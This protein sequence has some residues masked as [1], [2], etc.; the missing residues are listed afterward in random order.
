MTR[1][2]HLRFC[3]KCNNRK[4]DP[5]QGLVCSLTE[6]IADFNV[7]CKD[8]AKD[9]SVKEEIVTEERS[10]V[11]IIA[12]L[13]EEIKERLRM[14]QH[15]LF[16][17][18]GGL[19]VSVICALLWAVITVS[20]EYQIG[21]MALG[22]GLAVGLGVRFFGSGI[23]A[24]YGFIGA[25]LALLGCALGNLF[26]AVGFIAQAESLGY[27]DTIAFL[28]LSTMLAIFL[29]TFSLMDVLFY[30]IAAYEGYRF[31]FR[32]IPEDVLQRKDL[33]PDYVRFK[34]PLV[35]ASFMIITVSGYRLSK[36]VN[37][38][39]TF[40]YPSGAIMSS[41]EYLEGKMNGKWQHFDENGKQ[42]VLASYESGKENGEWEWY[43]E[44]G[45]LKKKGNYKNGLFD[46]QW[47]NYYENGQLNDSSNYVNGRLDGSAVSYYEN[48]Q[49]MSIGQYKRDRQDGL[50]VIFHGNGN[51]SSEG[52]FVAGEFR[53]L[54]KYW[55]E[56]GSPLQEFEFDTVGVYKIINAWDPKGSQ[57]VKNGNGEYRSYSEN[58]TLVWRG[59]VENGL[60]VG[61][62]ETFHT[63]GKRKEEGRYEGKIYKIQNSWDQ[64]GLLQV[65]KGEGEYITYYEN[66]S[67]VHEKGQIKNGLREGYW[68][69][70]Y[71]SS[72][73]Q[74]ES[75][76]IQG[77]LNGDSNSYYPNGTISVTGKFKNDGKEGE[78]KW[79]Y[80]SGQLHSSVNYIN[81]K[82]EGAQIFWSEFGNKS[83]EEIYESNKLVSE[84]LL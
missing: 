82:K 3:K 26:S 46:G 68:V 38:P 34:L 32:P 52:N 12:E 10:A 64:E 67:Q 79:F 2:E 45:S 49:K 25:L 24:I 80:E 54:W 31:A 37:G 57:M 9:T 6:K 84:K 13:P 42:R 33:T 71:D 1:E 41:G 61:S 36:G 53:G 55:N 35:I 78:W 18:I 48:G 81:N 60:K 28:D 30:G 76:Y 44:D 73:L 83:K 23:D 15:L 47:L 70:Y 69:T 4:L 43:N 72:L 27:W 16:A 63:N 5:Q 66:S 62:W 40:Y 59:R 19:F 14:H 51:K 56:D 21:Y 8:F 17:I 22:L 11:E 77:K 74:Q 29:E 58:G 75:N 20:T 50:W 39:Q 65:V 7:E